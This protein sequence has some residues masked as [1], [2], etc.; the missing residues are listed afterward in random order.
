MVKNNIE[1]EE[2][3]SGFV[4]FYNY[5]EPLM[6]FDQGFGYVGALVF[7][8]ETDKIQCHFCG[9]WFEALP[10]HL[11]REHNMK[12]EQ[13]K[14]RVG[15]LKTT[16]LISE[17][18]RAKLIASGL[19]Q[20]LKNLKP[21]GNKSE[22]VRKKISQTLKSSAKKSEWENLR[23]TCPAQIISRMQKIAEQKGNKLR[24]RDFDN[25]N[26]TIRKTYGTLK[27]ACRLAGIKYNKPGATFKPR[28]SKYTKESLIAELKRFKEINN[29]KPSFS[30]FRRGLLANDKTYN[31]IF[32]N[33]KNALSEAFN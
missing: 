11:K 19:N 26:A 16:A 4:T 13:Y 24:M 1:Y 2:A 15:L 12:T 29:R 31:R 17:S 9:D 5:K 32:G 30:D 20:R 18:Y 10:H 14:E 6:K 27:E 23:N 8:G 3:P 21:G 7:D 28:E 33:W 22:E 25:F